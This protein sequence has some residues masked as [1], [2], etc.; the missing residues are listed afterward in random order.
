MSWDNFIPESPLYPIVSL[1]NSRFCSFLLEVATLSSRKFDEFMLLQFFLLKVSTRKR[2]IA[3]SQDQ[4][5]AVRDG[6][7]SKRRH[8]CHYLP[9]LCEWMLAGQHSPCLCL[10]REEVRSWNIPSDLLD[11]R[12]VGFHFRV[13][14]YFD[15]SRFGLQQCDETCVS[16]LPY[17]LR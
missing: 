5:L 16:R 6:T 8:R 1:M 4:R 7:R 14:W 11:E 13:R 3:R 9:R 15:L 12:L 10:E 2:I 17:G